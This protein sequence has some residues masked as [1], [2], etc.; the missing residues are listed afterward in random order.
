MNPGPIGFY[1]CH[2]SAPAPK[3]ITLALANKNN[4]PHR[5]PIVKPLD[6]KAAKS[7]T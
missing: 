5:T 7:S 4:F 2:G 1:Y 6:R 3:Y